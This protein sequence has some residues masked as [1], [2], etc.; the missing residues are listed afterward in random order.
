[1]KTLANNSQDK[2]QEHPLENADHLE[3][4]EKKASPDLV[5]EKKALAPLEAPSYAEPAW[6]PSS[7]VEQDGG[8]SSAPAP[9][10]S[11][12]QA[13]AQAERPYD[14]SEDVLALIG[15]MPAAVVRN[16]ELSF[17]V[18]PVEAVEAVLVDVDEQ[19]HRVR[20]GTTSSELPSE[21]L[22]AAERCEY[23]QE[24]FRIRSVTGL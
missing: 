17:G 6:V 20:M 24:R 19:G 22:L 7:F 15:R 16:V 12:M 9:S 10:R 3:H 5:D 2:G 1:M 11:F 18:H 14:P 23:Q 21:G 13:A 4:P 8:G